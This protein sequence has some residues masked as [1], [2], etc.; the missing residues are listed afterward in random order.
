MNHSRFGDGSVTH[1]FFDYA[2]EV[3]KFMFVV[4]SRCA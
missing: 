4:P 2:A 3:R 1:D